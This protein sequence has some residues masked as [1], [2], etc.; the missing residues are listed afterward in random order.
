MEKT[1]IF[2]VF[3]VFVSLFIMGCNKMIGPVGLK[4]PNIKNME[5]EK[6]A[7][8]SGNEVTGYQYFVNE[9]SGNGE[10]LKLYSYMH[11]N[12]RFYSNLP[13]KLSDFQRC[14]L[15]DIKNYRMLK[16]IE[17]FSNYHFT[18]NIYGNFYTEINFDYTNFQLEI[19]T[20]SWD[21]YKITR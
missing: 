12:K 2:V 3:T 9:F 11:E 21:G 20:L 16:S 14:Y 10:I 4:K 13:A 15:F 7:I 18:D 6:F 5:Y 8:Y 1:L 17:N 19:Q